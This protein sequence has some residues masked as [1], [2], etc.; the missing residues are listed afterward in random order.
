V[1]I[2][3]TESL[4]VTQ[5]Q[6]EL[7]AGARFVF[8]EYCISLVFVTLRR[9]T[10]IFLLRAGERGLLRGLPYTLASLFL[11]WWGV[12]WGLVYTPQVLLTNLGGGRDVTEAARALLLASSGPALPASAPE[13][14]GQP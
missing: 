13:L 9:P 4:T 10:D 11:G 12:P 2:R 8:F 5:V 7:E 6:A 3:G 14:R 1:R